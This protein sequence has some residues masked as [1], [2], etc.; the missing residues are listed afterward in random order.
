M[1]VLAVVHWRVLWRAVWS[2]STFY[3][4][5]DY[6]FTL[7]WTTCSILTPGWLAIQMVQIFGGMD[8]CHIFLSAHVQIIE[9]A[10]SSNVPS[11]VYHVYY[12]SMVILGAENSF[13]NSSGAADSG[14]DRQRCSLNISWPPA[15]VFSITIYIKNTFQLVQNVLREAWCSR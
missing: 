8:G 2:D 4:L 3:F 11:Q 9:P 15:R 6:N 5:Y 10:T 12:Y 7:H 13:C 1:C 14:A